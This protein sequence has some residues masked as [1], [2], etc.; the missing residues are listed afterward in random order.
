[1]DNIGAGLVLNKKA[2]LY[3]FETLNMNIFWK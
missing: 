1:M 2:R 3:T